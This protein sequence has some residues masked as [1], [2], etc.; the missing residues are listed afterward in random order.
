MNKFLAM[1]EQEVATVGDL[2]KE[3]SFTPAKVLDEGNYFGYLCHY[4]DVGDQVKMFN[5]QANAPCPNFHLGVAL[6]EFNAE[7]NEWEFAKMCYTPWSLELKLNSKANYMKIFNAFA[8]KDDR[9]KHIAGFFGKVRNFYVSKTD[10]G[11][12]NNVEWAKTQAG[13]NPMTKQPIVLPEVDESKMCVFLWNNP[14]IEMFNKLNDR[15]KE[16]II[17]AH[18]FNGSAV[19]LMIQQAGNSIEMPKQRDDRDEVEQEKPVEPTEQPKVEK[20]TPKVARPAMAQAPAMPD[21]FD[22]DVEV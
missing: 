18:N 10:D 7:T 2:S 16:Q 9:P 13:I 11:K 5:G 19:D 12:Y 14:Q 21:E 1:V 17:N 22:E 15:T 4:A 20:A 8:T 3:Q 6:F